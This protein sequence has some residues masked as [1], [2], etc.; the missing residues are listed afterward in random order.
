MEYGLMHFDAAHIENINV[1][2]ILHQ[3]SL[4]CGPAFFDDAMNIWKFPKISEDVNI[5]PVCSRSSDCFVY[6]NCCPD[7]EIQFSSSDCRNLIIYSS[8]NTIKL[9]NKYAIVSNCPTGADT[10]LLHL[11]TQSRGIED[12]L[13]F[14]PVTSTTYLLTFK[15]KFCALCNGI[16]QFIPWK[17]HF[18]C[19]IKF[20]FTTTVNEIVTTAIKHQCSISY[21]PEQSFSEKVK[22]CRKSLLINKCNVTGT[23]EQYNRNVEY[24]CG[25]LNNP[26]L[27][28]KNIFCYMC[29]PPKMSQFVPIHNC[30]VTGLWKKRDENID[31]SC[32]NGGYSSATYPYK[33]IY[34]FIC[35]VDDFTF[36]TRKESW[37]VHV[38]PPGAVTY[39]FDYPTNGSSRMESEP[40]WCKRMY[41]EWNIK[42]KCK[43]P[44]PFSFLE[45]NMLRSAL[46]INERSYCNLTENV[47]TGYTICEKTNTTG[48]RTGSQLYIQWAC[49]TNL[50]Q[51][52]IKGVDRNFTLPQCGRHFEN[53]IMFERRNPLQISTIVQ[54]DLCKTFDCDDNQN[55]YP[56]KYF[57]CN[58]CSK[59]VSFLFPS[60]V[61]PPRLNIFS[62]S[63]YPT[64]CS[65]NEVF[66]TIQVRNSL[67]QYKCIVS[68]L[69][70]IFI[71]IY[72][73]CHMNTR[74]IMYERFQA[75]T[76][77]PHQ[78]LQL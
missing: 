55:I 54:S 31:I 72:L 61:Q 19:D 17:L 5:C 16:E 47:N 18:T 38:S 42:L 29:N 8:N 71:A 60:N 40:I 37:S 77:I 56:L 25:K 3:Y 45:N 68:L 69:Y 46:I 35:N 75:T 4:L 49:E 10:S 22:P 21:I 52:F 20:N 15:N 58:C 26:F 24:A 1:T 34:C 66:D 13:L 70:Y 39:Y 44:I 73:Q 76:P 12:G 43:F 53:K 28:Y 2:N 6:N 74:M 23:W 51:V 64:K 32:K 62:L 14:P 50:Y 33:N 65:Q 63:Y 67:L 48:C 7:L 78:L 27:P 59:Y 30:N 36:L 9:E 41:K 57:F 11:C